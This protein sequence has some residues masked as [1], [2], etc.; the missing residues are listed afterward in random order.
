MREMLPLI[1]QMLRD[2]H[3]YADVY[4][5][6]DIEVVFAV[7]I[8]WGDWKHE[9]LSAKWLLQE[10]GHV[11]ISS[12]VTEENGSDTYSAIHYFVYKEEN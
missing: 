4:P 3:V 1:E 8:N 5:Y 2:N 10:A 9:H 12:Q 6:R 7:E 11:Y